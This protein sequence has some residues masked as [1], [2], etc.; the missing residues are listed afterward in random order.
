[1]SKDQH[2]LN[3]YATEEKERLQR[4]KSSVDIQPFRESR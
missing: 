4:N 2:V 3:K 1:M